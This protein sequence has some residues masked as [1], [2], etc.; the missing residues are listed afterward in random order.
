[1][2]SLV[3]ILRTFFSKKYLILFLFLFSLLFYLPTLWHNFV[4]DDLSVLSSEIHNIKGY[5]LFLGHGDYYRPFMALAHGLDYALWYT[6]PMGFHLTNI[7]LNA[8]CSIAAY[9]VFARLLQGRNTLLPYAATLLF[10]VHPAHAGSVAWIADRTDLI[11]TFFFLL[12]F[13][14]YILYREENDKRILSLSALFFLFSLFGKEVGITLPLIVLS[15]DLLIKQNKI[16]DTLAAQIPF[17]LII[18]IYFL[19]RHIPT[20]PIGIEGQ[21]HAGKPDILIFLHDLALSYGFYIKKLFVPFHLSIFPDIND[22]SNLLFLGFFLLVFL[23]SVIKRRHAITFSLLFVF[24]S[25]L[26]SMPVV[27]M[28]NVPT[29]VA[30][31]YLYLPVFG[32]SLLIVHVIEKIRSNH[33][34]VVFIA[35][36]A[37]YGI[38]CS[39]R[40]MEWKN[41]HALWAS[42]VRMNNDSALAHLLLSYALYDEKKYAGSEKECTYVI[43]NIESLRTHKMQKQKFLANAYNMLGI[44]SIDR[45]DFNAA[46]KHLYK[47]MGCGMKNRSVFH[48]LGTVYLSQY[49]INKNTALLKDANF[50]YRE[51]TLHDSNYLD[52]AYALAYTT[53]LLGR[54][55]EAKKL[56]EKVINIDPRSPLA[57][58]AV[59]GIAS[60][61]NSKK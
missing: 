13:L 28:N 25:I 57:L 3:K 19:L 34:K 33:I 48:N 61:E 16:K 43:K 5:R 14:S 36:A 23:L 53:H 20:P 41:N 24:L 45:K 22:L 54:N 7:M 10:I 52:S 32:F 18:V 47:A 17:Y 21:P 1:L 6:N 35:L 11:A 51:A 39:W 9:F 4:W 59:K 40:Y 8:L 26:P 37:I 31:R 15:Y 56:Y 44:I 38:S 12:S 49:L 50:M 55:E 29:P 27:L 2:S 58:L 30:V 60:I 46:E 42:E